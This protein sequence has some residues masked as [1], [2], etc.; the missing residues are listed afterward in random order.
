MMKHC[1]I[2]VRNEYKVGREIKRDITKRNLNSI[3]IKFFSLITHG[4]F[5]NIHKFL[6]EL[7]RE[8]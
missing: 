4:I 2:K 3:S 5:I 8:K 1:G 6:Y 7:K